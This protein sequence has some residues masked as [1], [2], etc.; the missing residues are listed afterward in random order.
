MHLPLVA[1]KGRSPSR[2][3][4]KATESKRRW[5][6]DPPERSSGSFANLQLLMGWARD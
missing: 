6:T 2:D 5:E 1:K 3:F 4:G